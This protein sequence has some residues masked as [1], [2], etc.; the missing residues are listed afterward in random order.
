MNYDYE[1]DPQ[2][3]EQQPKRRRG[4]LFIAVTIIAIVALLASSIYSIFWIVS[5]N[6]SRETTSPVVVQ[7]VTAAPATAV[8]SP[9]VATLAATTV[10]AE[11]AVV[12]APEITL[13]RLVVVNEEAQL[14][15]V[16][17]DGSDRRL[18]TGGQRVYQFP[19]WSP[20][21]SQ[22]AAIG[23][24]LTGGGI[25]VL[26]DTA[27]ADNGREVYFSSRNSPFYLYW[28]PDSQRISFLANHS[29][30][31]IGLN[32]VDTAGSDDSRVI[33]TGSPLYWNWTADSDGMLIHTG[34]TTDPRLALIDDTGRSRQPNVP[35]PGF[36]Q[37]PGIS[38]DGR[39]WAYSQFKE[40]GLSWLVVN[41]TQN[42]EVF[43][44]R[45][46]GALALSWSPTSNQL[47]YIS[48][49]ADSS[50][51][52]GPLRLWNLATGETRLLSNEMV[53]AFFWS[54]DGRKIAYITSGA[55]DLGGV[56]VSAPD[57]DRPRRLARAAVQQ[58]PHS[59]SLFVVD[60][61]TG[62]GLRLADF[63]PSR[64]FLAQFL[65]FFDQYA[66]SHRLWSPAS[67]ALVLPMVEGRQS[68]I[69]VVPTSGAQ[70]RTIGDG[71]M[72]FWSHQ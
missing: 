17:P 65:P 19:A 15:T 63:T 71:I 30:D 69:V 47:A 31:G 41:D 34:S 28:S 44:E 59:F 54:P 70:M 53:L 21:G 18:L 68:Q 3:D 29:S 42:G 12:V 52:W 39:Y 37:V 16:A 32:L 55:N 9:A 49:D 5:R 13:N 14:E 27:D 48:G 66:L 43:S 61:A 40:G 60:V 20:D 56:E 46:A 38:A 36:F 4:C 6:D 67:N 22:I 33:A 58:G 26:E 62:A 10:P 1:P 2:P 51:F 23:G 72:A 7:E 50:T 35:D 25:Y 8:A 45:H 24:T 11:P 57:A 64:L